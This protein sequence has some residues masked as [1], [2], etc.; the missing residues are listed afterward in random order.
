MDTYRVDAKGLAKQIA[1]TK[2]KM[3]GIDR[4]IVPL[5][6]TL[7]VVSARLQEAR[8]AN[9]DQPI[10]IRIV[11]TAV[12]PQ[13]PLPAGQGMSIPLAAILGLSLGIVLALFVHYLQ[14][15]QPVPEKSTT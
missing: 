14:N 13:S 12:Q 15:P 10:S 1:E 6:S 5:E 7:G 9:A 2:L 3:S 8:I 4:Q 11:E